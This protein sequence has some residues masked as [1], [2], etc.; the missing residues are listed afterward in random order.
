MAAATMAG[1]ATHAGIRPCRRPVFLGR[2]G[3]HLLASYQPEEEVGKDC[4]DRSDGDQPRDQQSL[5]QR[6]V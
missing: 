4:C 3:S 6:C 5:P 2:L 1:M